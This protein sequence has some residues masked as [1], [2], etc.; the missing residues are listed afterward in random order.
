M[1]PLKK[2]L[3]AVCAVV[4]ASA[5][6]VVA[7]VPQSLELLLPP[8]T[9]RADNDADMRK[10]IAWLVEH[11]AMVDRCGIDVTDRRLVAEIDDGSV[12]ADAESAGFV[13]V[14]DLSGGGAAPRGGVDPQY[15]DP[16]D[17][18]AYL[19][20]VAID[21]PSITRVFSIGTTTQG[22]DILAIEISDH[23]GVDEDEP[24][25]LLNGLHHAREVVTPHI[26]TDAIATLVDGYAANDPQ[27]VA[28][29]RDYKSILIP[30][31]NPDGSARVFA[32]DPGQRKN[33]RP[34]CTTTNPG[35]DLNRNYPYKWGSGTCEAGTGSSGFDCSDSYR[36]PAAASEPETQ[37]MIALAETMHFAI[38][39]SYHSYGRFIDYP[40]AC[41]PGVPDKRMPEH[42][43]INAMMFDMANAISGVDGVNYAVHS[44]VAL[45]PV[46]GDDTSW[47]YAYEGTYPFI[48]ETTT[49]FQPPFS[50]VAGIVARN[51]AGWK[52][53]Y[54]RLSQARIDVH[55]AS[56]CEPLEANV[57]LLNYTYDTGELPR[58]T[59]LPFGRWTYL[60]PANNSY[61]VRV[62]KDGYQPQDVVV[63]VGNAP[64]SLDVELV[65]DVPGALLTGD[66]NADCIVDGRDI[67]LFSQAMLDGDAAAAPQRARGD[68]NGDCLVTALDLPAFVAALLA[69]ASCP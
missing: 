2:Y 59:F 23:P 29:V 47:Y 7:D 11:G 34:V 42:D 26:V 48:V 68:A 5:M 51:R 16:D 4:C 54:A 9:D 52:S 30:M 50:E 65:P 61:T 22:R 64:V 41:N 38:A 20:Q 32:N 28:W 53:L 36:G 17:V 33:L 43:A 6:P 3:A 25:I 37:A 67:P 13:V 58:V 63:A 60:V 14:R 40:Y 69:T 39:V 12:V 45:G 24:A 27:I 19:N 55:V 31:V 44:P 18:E 66:M 21:H 15:L 49:Q 56:G 10:A 35:V 46:N 8:A 62:T 57:T 1:H